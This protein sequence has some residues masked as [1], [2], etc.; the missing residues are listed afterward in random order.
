V[1]GVGISGP[2]CTKARTAAFQSLPPSI[3]KLAQAG[4]EEKVMTP[5]RCRSSGIHAAAPHLDRGKFA[6][7]NCG[8]QRASARR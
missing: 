7:I 3:E 1:L 2:A 5:I 6:G 8:D 4:C